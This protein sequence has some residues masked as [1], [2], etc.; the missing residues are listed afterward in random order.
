MLLDAKAM[1]RYIPLGKV[2]VIRLTAVGRHVAVIALK[3][4][5]KKIV[6]IRVFDGPT[7]TVNTTYRKL[8]VTYT[9]FAPMIAATAPKISSE[10]PADR[11]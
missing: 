3:N 6:W 9:S 5:R 2:F 8:P 4:I 11:A 10:Q 7:A 1:L